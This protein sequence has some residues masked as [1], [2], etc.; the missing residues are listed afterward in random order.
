MAK[1]AQQTAPDMRVVF[2]DISR[3]FRAGNLKAAAQKM[4][5]ALAQWP[6][7]VNF[8]HLGGLIKQHS[9][10]IKGANK[11]LR[12]AHALRPEQPDILHNL[13]V[14]LLSTG[15]PQDAVPL[16]EKLTRLAPAQAHLWASYGHALRLS[17]RLKESLQAFT[18]AQEIDPKMSMADVMAMTRRQLVDWSMPDPTPEQIPANLAPVFIRDARAHLAC[19]KRA[20]VS[21]KPV[22]SFPPRFLTRGNGRIRIGYLSNDLHDHA[23]SYLLAELF[24]LHDRSKF[25]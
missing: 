11:M 19:V 1:P 8:L 23:T 6:G 13:A 15:Q 17:G 10:D 2:E 16:F 12:E 3:D 18:H 9:G 24:G 21:I 5:G 7:N 14:F 4:D 25:E 20:A 22:A